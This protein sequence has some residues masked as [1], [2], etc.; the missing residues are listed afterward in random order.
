MADSRA[1]DAAQAAGYSVTDG[2]VEQELRGGSLD[3]LRRVISGD[4]GHLEYID[5][6]AADSKVIYAGVKGKEF[7][8]S[9]VAR[10][11]VNASL[12]TDASQGADA[13]IIYTAA[14]AGAG[15]GVA[16]CIKVAYAN[17]ASDGHSDVVASMAISSGVITVTVA[18]KTTVTL[19][20][21]VITALDAVPGL[22]KVM[23][24]ELKT[25]NDGTGAVATLAATALTGG[26]APSGTA[27]AAQTPTTL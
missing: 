24:Y 27:E 12:D 14:G 16:P 20:S 4:G 2:V 1:V 19:A 26:V 13:A 15:Y 9:E 3:R 17:T 7:T 8:V 22:D 5:A 21:E 25:G 23:T 10:T 18:I 11:P 6:E